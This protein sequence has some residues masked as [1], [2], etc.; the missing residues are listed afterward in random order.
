M[1]GVEQFT[2][3]ALVIIFILTVSLIVYPPKAKKETK[4]VKGSNRTKLAGRLGAQANE[5]Q[6]LSVSEKKRM[7]SILKD[8][9]KGKIGSKEAV[10]LLHKARRY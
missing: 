4:F 7:T 8:F 5:S 2:I 9:S 10:E 3:G 6:T 1:T